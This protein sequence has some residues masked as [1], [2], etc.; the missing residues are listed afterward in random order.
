MENPFGNKQKI[1]IAVL[2]FGF[3]GF[4]VLAAVGLVAGT[5]AIDGIVALSVGV[6]GIMCGGA[7]A[8]DFTRWRASREEGSASDDELPP[9]WEAK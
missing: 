9:P 6:Y 7:A 8:A 5:A 4:L 3:T 2:A 1:G